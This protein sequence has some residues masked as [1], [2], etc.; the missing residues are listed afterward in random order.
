[1]PLRTLAIR[2]RGQNSIVNQS[3]EEVDSSPLGGG[4]RLQCRKQLQ[5]Y[6]EI[7]RELDLEVGPEDV[8]ELLRSWRKPEW[9]R[10]CFS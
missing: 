10:S 8:A 9:M 4:S 6:V 3:T 2:G 7:A 5:I 1:M